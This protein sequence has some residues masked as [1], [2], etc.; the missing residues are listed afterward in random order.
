MLS[1]KWL[2]DW[3]LVALVSYWA[4][5]T[6][7]SG[8]RSGLWSPRCDLV[9]GFLT[10]VVGGAIVFLVIRS[11]YRDLGLPVPRSLLIGAVASGVLSAGG[12]WLMLGNE[13]SEKDFMMTALSSKPISEIQ[14]EYKALV[15]ELF[16]KELKRDRDYQQ[17]SSQ[18]KPLN[19]PLFSNESFRSLPIMQGE[20]EGVNEVIALDLA[21]YDQHEHNLGEFQSAMKKRHSDLLKS[22]NSGTRSKEESLQEIISLERQFFDATLDLYRFAARNPENIIYQHGDLVSHDVGIWN[23]FAEKR[24]NCISLLQRLQRLMPKRLFA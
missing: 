12:L 22:F 24:N 14:P 21:A 11:R 9:S 6:P 18:L 5:D 20:V 8:Y 7:V 10:L 1:K 4:L 23:T 13:M 16:R 15:V 2:F 3:S 19:P 17:K